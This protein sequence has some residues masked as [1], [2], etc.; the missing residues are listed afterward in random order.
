MFKNLAEIHLYFWNSFVV[1]RSHVVNLGQ[2]W[3]IKLNLFVG[4]KNTIHMAEKLFKYLYLEKEKCFFILKKIPLLS[5]DWVFSY[6]FMIENLYKGHVL[7][8]SEYSN[9]NPK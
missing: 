6:L 5:K 3:H 9:R 2:I 4:A 1:K 8:K 7:A